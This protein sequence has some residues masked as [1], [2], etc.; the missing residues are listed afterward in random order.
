MLQDRIRTDAYRDAICQ[1]PHLFTG[2]TVLDVGCGTGVLSIF[3]ARAGA[4]QVF[5]VD[6]SNI[7]I[8]A[9]QIILDNGLDKVVTI[10][11]GEVE[12]VELPVKTV[13]IIVSEWMGFS[14]FTEG[15]LD[16]VIFARDKW[17][18][19]GG[20]IFPDI[21]KLYI[22][23]IQ[24]VQY[25]EDRL[26]FQEQNGF[27]FDPLKTLVMNES[28]VDIVGEEDVI[29]DVA[30]LKEID[31]QVI[32]M[33]EVEFDT[34]FQL[35]LTRKGTLTGLT[36]YFNVE[37]SHCHLPVQFST[38]PGSPP[39]HWKQTSFHLERNYQLSDRDL[40][41][42][43]VNMCRSRDSY[44]SFDFRIGVIVEKDKTLVEEKLYHL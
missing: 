25:K 16:S 20:L 6:N 42:G 40:V 38:S 9:K 37:F 33:E 26:E 19:S 5:G 12:E 44:R 2:K 1:N 34:V 18:G 28:V 31:L 8:Q 21:F 35:V 39:T 4:K 3:A 32:K 15:M 30:L 10:I 29:T 43:I 27:K 36:T 41:K 14:L 24:D 13:D 23:G 11:Q 17:L 22:C 7:A